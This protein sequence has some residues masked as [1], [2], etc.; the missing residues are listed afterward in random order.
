ML[1]HKLW[2]CMFVTTNSTSHALVE[3]LNLKSIKTFIKRSCQPHAQH[4]IGLWLPIH[5]YC[6]YLTAHDSVSKSVWTG[7]LEQE[8]QMV[9]LSA[10]RCSCI[11]ILWAS[12][13]SFAAITLCVASW[14]SVVV[15]FVTNSVQ[16]PLDTPLYT[17]PPFQGLPVSVVTG[18]TLSW[19]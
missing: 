17:P 6:L 12:L 10:T 11:T 13:V 15:Y 9:Q 7:C 1:L 5:S 2:Q 8:L 3:F 19:Q 18:T 14:V 16:K 4:Q